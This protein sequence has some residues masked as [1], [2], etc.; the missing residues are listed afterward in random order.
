[1][2]FGMSPWLG[3]YHPGPEQSWAQQRSEWGSWTACPAPSQENCRL[4]RNR[5]GMT[6]KSCCQRT[7]PGSVTGE[8]GA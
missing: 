2:Q 7:V 5:P 6:E 8:E 3:S 4:R 1:M